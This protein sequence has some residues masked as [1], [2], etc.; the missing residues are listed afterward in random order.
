MGKDRGEQRPK[1]FLL[2]RKFRRQAVPV[3]LEHPFC[4]IHPVVFGFEQ[5][6]AA[7]FPHDRDKLAEQPRV[8]AVVPGIQDAQWKAVG[9]IR[10]NGRG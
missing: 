5:R 9:G 7:S 6:V 2:L 10:L 3:V 1:G 4:G 8:E